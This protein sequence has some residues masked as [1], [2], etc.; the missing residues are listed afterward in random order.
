MRCAT[1]IQT[2]G[3]EYL[4]RLKSTQP[5]LM[6]EARRTLTGA[7]LGTLR[8]EGGTLEHRIWVHDLEGAGWLGWE[9]AGS[10]VRI[11]RVRR[12]KGGE[13]RLG[14]RLWVSSLRGLELSQWAGLCR[15]HWGCENGQH[16][17]ADKHMGEDRRMSHLSREP[18]VLLAVS[19]LRAMAI[20]VLNTLKIQRQDGC[21]VNRSYK[22]VRQQVSSVL[23]R[24]LGPRKEAA[25][26]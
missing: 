1:Q 20:N 3:W 24:P 5:S 14:E 15:G 12:S 17:V 21:T 13:E 7:P 18:E 19:V 4:M 2:Q 9:H 11:E 6:A 8:S 10:F 25:F 16:C 23:E 22:H 26:V